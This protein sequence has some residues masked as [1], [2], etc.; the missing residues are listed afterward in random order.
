MRLLAIASMGLYVLTATAGSPP[1]PEPAMTADDLQQ[2]C[3]GT[4]H[5]SRNVCRVYI[6]GVTQG[7]TLGMRMASS[8]IAGARPCVPEGISAQT[9]EQTLK[10]KLEQDLAATPA[11]RGL[12]ASVFV[13]RVLIAA[14]PCKPGR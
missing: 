6:L 13:G 12:D 9:L 10:A 4:D 2:L 3:A 5:V 7:V 14:Y 8:T 11:D 1:K